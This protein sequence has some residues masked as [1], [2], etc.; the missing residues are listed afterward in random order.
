[1]STDGTLYMV[2]DNAVTG[3]VD[4]P[5]PPL[6]DER[7]LLMRIPAKGVEPRDPLAD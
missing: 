5:E 1:V 4:D 7:T 2:S 3:V 6:T